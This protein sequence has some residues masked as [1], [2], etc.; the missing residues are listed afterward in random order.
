MK[1]F[2]YCFISALMAVTLLIGCSADNNAITDKSDITSDLEDGNEFISSET[3]G[4]EAS[5]SE[6]ASDDRFSSVAKI[7]AEFNEEK[8]HYYD[9]FMIY[10]EITMAFP[11]LHCVYSVGE[12]GAY[13]N[14][15]PDDWFVIGIQ[16][17]N[18][19]TSDE[20]R[21]ALEHIGAI[22][23]KDHPFLEGDFHN[24]IAAAKTDS[25]KKALYKAKH[26]LMYPNLDPETI[27]NMQPNL[28]VLYEYVGY[29]TRPMI[30]ELAKAV[31]GIS[32][33][34]TFMPEPDNHDS[35]L[36]FLN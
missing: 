32:V 10:E 30:N 29:L 12:F 22:E 33:G 20:L 9:G 11:Y 24:D 5:L 7:D 18:E 27:E 34:Y 14:A 35:W 2:I 1:R 23:I 17:S 21:T 16:A 31:D 36:K 3:E 15:Q 13:E 8:V 26:T 6:S 28:P 4:T 25:E 19:I